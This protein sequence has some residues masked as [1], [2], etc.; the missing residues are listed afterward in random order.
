MLV[1]SCVG[2][3]REYIVGYLILNI[4]CFNYIV[5][6][7][8]TFPQQF[9]KMFHSSIL[10]GSEP[11]FILVIGSRLFRDN[12]A[13]MVVFEAVDSLLKNSIRNIQSAKCKVK[14]IFFNSFFLA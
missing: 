12:I 11:A 6:R 2:N 4:F 8:V 7:V 9:S 13:V 3:E 14:Q 10:L 1:I 5:S